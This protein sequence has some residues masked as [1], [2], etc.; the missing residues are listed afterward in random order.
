MQERNAFNLCIAIFACILSNEH[1]EK[2]SEFVSDFSKWTKFSHWHF[3]SEIFVYYLCWL[4]KKVIRGQNPLEKSLLC[5]YHGWRSLVDSPRKKSHK[6]EKVEKGNIQKLTMYEK[7]LLNQG[8]CDVIFD[9]H[10]MLL[11]QRTWPMAILEVM[12]IR[13]LAW[14]GF[15]TW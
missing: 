1:L 8:W 6:C 4:D 2:S 13:G 15:I 5:Q 14:F 9:L 11:L 3:L 12:S 7:E 10:L